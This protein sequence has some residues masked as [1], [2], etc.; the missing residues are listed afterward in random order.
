MRCWLL[1]LLA[2]VLAGA[3]SAQV[4]DTDC[5][6]GSV[7][8][9]EEPEFWC[10]RAGGLRHGPMWTTHPDGSLAT[11]GNAVLGRL[12]GRWRSWHPSGGLS[13]ESH[14]SN[15]TVVGTI[16]LWDAA[17]QLTFEGDHDAQGRMHGTF[18]KWWPSGD[19]RVT[20]EMEHG[21]RHG[22]VDAFYEGGAVRMRG[23]SWQGERDG[24]WQFWAPD[25]RLTGSCH[26]ERGRL[27]EGTCPA[28][29]PVR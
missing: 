17:G 2:P 28:M 25:G 14:F 11:H 23:R 5:P 27:V 10:E 20:W 29:G 13:K 16:R 19:L 4:A 26:Y 12:H 22:K 6:P 1:A 3:A 7:L 15:D 9:A 18:R 8:R 21:A 24:T